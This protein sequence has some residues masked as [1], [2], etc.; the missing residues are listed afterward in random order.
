MH[1][2]K[3]NARPVENRPL[4]GGDGEAG[5]LDFAGWLVRQRRLP[6]GLLRRFKEIFAEFKNP[7]GIPRTGSGLLDV[8]LHIRFGQAVADTDAGAHERHLGK[9]RRVSQ[10]KTTAVKSTH[11]LAQ[12]EALARR[13]FAFPFL[14]L[15]YVIVAVWGYFVL[16][17]NLSA[18]RVAGI[19]TIIL[20]TILISRS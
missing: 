7:L 17:E 10:S 16:G 3:T 19:A 8:V 6:G 2:N 9:E 15:A 4:K 20:G 1:R 12:D 11:R 14:S 5:G 13:A 18:T